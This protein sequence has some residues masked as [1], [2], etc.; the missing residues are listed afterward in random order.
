MF[1]SI[2]I[3]VYNV[4]RWLAACLDSVLSQ[5]FTDYEI[6]IVDDCSPDKSYEIYEAYAK[7]H[8]CITVLKHSVNKRLGGVRNTGIRAAKGEWIVFLD[9]DDLMAQGALRFYYEK[10]LKTKDGYFACIF[11]RI[12]ENN[13]TI[14]DKYFDKIF[15]ILY[16]N[17]TKVKLS[18]HTVVFLPFLWGKC[19]NRMFILDNDLFFNE[20]VLFEDVSFNIKLLLIQPRFICYNKIVLHYRVNSESV[21]YSFSK[22]N[23]KEK[24]AHI[25]SMNDWFFECKEMHS[26]VL[27]SAQYS[28]MSFIVLYSIIFQAA[29]QKHKYMSSTAIS[30]LIQS[31]ARQNQYD[32]QRGNCRIFVIFKG[33]PR[34]LLPA[35]LRFLFKLWT[36]YQFLS[37]LWTLY[38]KLF[39]KNI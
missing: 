7:Q 39:K 24:V 37:K 9:S 31:I 8:S 26:L 23:H 33:V 35:Y 27:Q 25:Q 19:Y 2:I 15:S 18:D 4:E 13:Y 36:L 28:Y 30:Y 17:K 29:K 1:F 6:I 10:A 32:K 21:T 22:S 11:D 5:D 38:K 20:N 12:D 3:P 16:D 34:Y 14:E